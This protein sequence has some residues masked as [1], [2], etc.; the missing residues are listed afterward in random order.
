MGV[1]AD[2]ADGIAQLVAGTGAGVYSTSVAYTASQVGIVL[3][4]VP[5]DPDQIIAVTVYSPP[6]NDPDP[7]SADEYLGLQFWLRGSSGDP[8]PVQDRMDLIFSALHGAENQTF[9]SAFMLLAWR[10]NST[11]LGQDPRG[12]SEAVANYRARLYHP[13]AHTE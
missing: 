7:R 2:F 12:R 8:R 10:Y 4:E 11:H 5:A 9:G 6:D 13:T 3:G 1:T